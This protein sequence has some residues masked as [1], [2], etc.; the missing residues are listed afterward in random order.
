[1]ISSGDVRLR[2]WPKLQYLDPDPILRELRALERE[3]ADANMEPK[4][5][6][7]RT[8]KLQEHLQRRQA[9][10]FC[11]GLG[12]VVGATVSFAPVERADFDI[13][14]KRVEAGTELYTPVQ[15]KELVPQQLN[16]SAD[17]QSLLLSLKKYAAS[18]DLVIGIHVNRAGR[19][20]LSA[21]NVPPLSVSE[22]WLYGSITENQSRW[23][24]YGNLLAEPQKYEFVYPS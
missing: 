18:Q 12:Q 7:L 21:I 11:F 14:T 15:L 24:L 23:L 17:L 1:M 2:E 4:V 16:P 13:V 9:A 6:A 19:M 22:I 5:R 10:L 8:R 3:L 20:D